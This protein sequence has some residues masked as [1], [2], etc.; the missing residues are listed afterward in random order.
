[1]LG[2]IQA[3][4]QSPARMSAN[5]HNIAH[6]QLYSTNH[7]ACT[8]DPVDPLRVA[9]LC[10][11]AIYL[12]PYTLSDVLHSR[13]AVL[14]ARLDA[15]YKAACSVREAVQAGIAA[16]RSMTSTACQIAPQA[17]PGV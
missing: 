4:A 6:G 1:M 16:V 17:P 5:H 11:P 7:I 10:A 12:Y 14:A 3:R 8:A 13:P 2:N 9:A 15:A